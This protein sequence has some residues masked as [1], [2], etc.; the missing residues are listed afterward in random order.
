MMPWMQ[1]SQGSSI[2]GSFDADDLQR[3]L[4]A[5]I[6]RYVICEVCF[7]P[8]IDLRVKGC[9]ILADCRTCGHH[10]GLHSFP[11]TSCGAEDTRLHGLNKV[12]CQQCKHIDDFNNSHQSRITHNRGTVNF[13]RFLVMYPLEDLATPPA[14]PFILNICLLNETVLGTS[15]AGVHVFHIPFAP[16]EVVGQLRVRAADALGIPPLTLSFFR[17]AQEVLNEDAQWDLQP[18]VVKLKARWR[19]IKDVRKE[20]EATPESASESES[21]SESSDDVVEMSLGDERCKSVISG[22]AAWA[23]RKE[24]RFSPADLFEELRVLQLTLRFDNSLRMYVA[25]S[26]LFP[27][28]SMDA[29]GVVEKRAHVECFVRNGN[30]QFRDWIWAFDAFLGANP[31]STKSY[32]TVLKALYDA[33]LAEEQDLLAH[34]G[35]DGEAPGFQAA[36]KAAAPFLA[37]LKTAAS[38]SD[39]G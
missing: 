31:Q 8:G 14:L 23:E 29:Q 18:L 35:K 24:S 6:C 3:L 38:D 28:G 5:F 25:L 20:R 19:S 9:A 32:P 39:N 4:D 1:D 10:R 13:A 7:G 11:C 30:M 2:S 12:I 37:W 17:G 26:V 27:G 15:L 16:R 22:L 21:E 33:D 34:Y 36:R